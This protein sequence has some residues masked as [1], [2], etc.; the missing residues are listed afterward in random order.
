MNQSL[1]TILAKTGHFDAQKSASRILLFSSSTFFSVAVF[2]PLQG[3]HGFN[4]N[5]TVV[6]HRVRTTIMCGAVNILFHRIHVL[7]FQGTH[8]LCT[9]GPARER[10]WKSVW[11]GSLRTCCKGSFDLD[12]QYFQLV[13]SWTHPFHHKHTSSFCMP[14]VWNL[15]CQQTSIYQK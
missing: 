8:T 1:T 11:Q 9:S 10:Q 2:S 15:H 12:C 13:R 4:E 7:P 6:L 5:N 14:S 3:N